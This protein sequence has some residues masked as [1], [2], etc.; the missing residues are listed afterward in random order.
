[1]PFAS[2]TVV[3]IKAPLASNKATVTPATGALSLFRLSPFRSSNKV[4]DMLT[5]SKIP[6]STSVMLVVLTAIGAVTPLAGL[7]TSLSVASLVGVAL[8]VVKLYPPAM[9][10]PTK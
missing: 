8:G 4:P 5:G 1:M 9:P 3:V 2:V 7:I 6:A 10:N